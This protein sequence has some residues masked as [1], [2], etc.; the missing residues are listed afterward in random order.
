[1]ERHTLHSIKSKLSTN[2]AIV[3]KADK[4][5]TVVITYLDDYH[6]KVHEFISNNQSSKANNDLNNTFQKEINYTINDCVHKWNGI[7]L[8]NTYLY[9]KQNVLYWPDNDR[10]RPKHVATV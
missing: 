6:L 5:N 10:L 8:S 2:N 4:G 7:P 9:L 3:L 1:M